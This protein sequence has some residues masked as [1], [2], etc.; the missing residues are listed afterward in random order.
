MTDAARTAL[1]VVLGLVVFCLL[2]TALITNGF[3]TNGGDR[4]WGYVM[5]TAAAVVGLGFLASSGR[6][7]PEK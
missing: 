4:S 6:V 3:Q 2:A 5:L 1:G 7:N